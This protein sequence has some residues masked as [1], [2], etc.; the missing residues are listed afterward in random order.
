MLKRTCMEAIKKDILML[1]VAEAM[2]LNRV[3]WKKMI[4][5]ANPKS[6]G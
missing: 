1:L 5:V 3:E 2:D 4:Y 6:L